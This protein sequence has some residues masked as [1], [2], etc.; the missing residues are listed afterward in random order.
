MATLTVWKFD[1]AQGATE[2][3]EKLGELQKQQLVQLFDAATVSWPTGVSGLKRVK[4]L[5]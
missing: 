3:V 2:A 1:T 4:P 5:I